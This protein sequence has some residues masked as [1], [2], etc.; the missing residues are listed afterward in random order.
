MV[1][2]LLGYSQEAIQKQG[3]TEGDFVVEFGSND[4]CLLR[5]YKEAGMRVLGVDPARN[6]AEMA[7]A[8]GIPTIPEFFNEE[9]GTKIKE[10]HGEPKLICANHCCAHIDDLPGVI[11]GVKALLSPDGLF[12]MEVGYLLSVFTGNL[13]D[14]IYHEHCDFHR[15]APLCGFFARHGLKLVDAKHVDIQG[16]SLRCGYC[17]VY[18]M[19]IPALCSV[20]VGHAE[21]AP[22]AGGEG[23]V[24]ELIR[25]EAVAGLNSV[26]TFQ[27]WD[28]RIHATR[29]ELMS[30]ISGALD[31]SAQAQRH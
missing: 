26:S 13:F 9:I 5:H 29:I 31:D 25:L 2:H 24:M 3:L 22:I 17:V 6:L 11:R 21:R 7:T 1:N 15:V 20:F 12:I 30:L 18:L 23:R 16:G 10:E 8:S 4:G 27:A 14:T 19:L 28:A